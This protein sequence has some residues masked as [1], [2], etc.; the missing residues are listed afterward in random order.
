MGGGESAC[1]T[2]HLRPNKHALHGDALWWLQ[3]C[4]SWLEAC[5]CCQLCRVRKRTA[6]TPT[7][8][9]AGNYLRVCTYYMAS[10]WLL[11]TALLAS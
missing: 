4:V 10:A 5:V 2:Q 6:S 11:R 8:L 7:A 1:D 9:Q 3:R